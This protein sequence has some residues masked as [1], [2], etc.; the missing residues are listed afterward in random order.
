MFSDRHRAAW[1]ELDDFRIRSAT[2]IDKLCPLSAAD[3]AP[4]LWD[5]QFGGR[6]ALDRAIFQRS[7]ELKSTLYGNRLFVIVPMYVTSICSE[8]CVYCNYRAGNKGRGVERRRLN[9]AEIEQE[10]RYL[11][12]EKGHR[13]LELVYASD[14]AIRVDSMC[15]HVELLRR[16]VEQQGG[17]VVAISAEALEENEY[18]QLVNAGLSISV[19]WQETYDKTRYAFLH[20][21]KNRKTDFGYRIDSYER[22]LAAGVPHV[23]IGILLGLSEWKH[24][25]AM[26]LLHEEYLHR[27]CGRGASILGTPRLKHAPGALLQESPYTPNQQEFLATIALHNIFS[28]TT[29]AFVSTRESWEVC[30]ELARG[31]GCLFTLDCSTTPGGYSLRRGGCQ[32]TSGSYDSAIY[33]NKLRTEGFGPVFQWTN[34]D[35]AKSGR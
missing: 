18:R 30:V 23:G 32:F 1:N 10:A 21:G 27:H 29:A 16:V 2:A 31:G 26:L 3:F 24:D 5:R 12:E 28:P 11:V 22:M 8:Q 33:T 7:A 19:L 6:G 9:D 15:R 17:G 25:W 13:V 4:L 35:L 20:P 34:H 14:P